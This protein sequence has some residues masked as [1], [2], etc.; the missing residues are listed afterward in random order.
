MIGNPSNRVSVPQPA[1][2]GGGGSPAG[3]DGSIQWND[4]GS[5]AG[6]D[7]LTFDPTTSTL[8]TVQIGSAGFPGAIILI[9]PDGFPV[10][11]LTPLAPGQPQFV[12]LPI[13]PQAGYLIT[14]ESDGTWEYIDPS[15]GGPLGA[16]YDAIG[17]AAD[18]AANLST[19]VAAQ[20]AV[21]S[22]LA[23][24]IAARSSAGIVGTIQLADGV[25]GFLAGDPNSLT[26]ATLRLQSIGAGTIE[27]GNAILSLQ[28]M[29][30]AIQAQLAAGASGTSTP[31][32]GSVTA[33]GGIVTLI[34]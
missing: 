10:Q 8:S 26:L 27:V 16:F 5:F 3:P 19:A 23:A 31:T 7:T 28:T 18:V 17:A 30:A 11:I 20:A 1:G 12:R 4:S 25:G 13:N 22:T 24:G 14:T 9:A 32:T 21:N 29:V 33:V 15:G 2:G 34:T 6:N